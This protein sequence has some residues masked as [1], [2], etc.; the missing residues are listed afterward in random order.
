MCDLQLLLAAKDSIQEVY[1]QLILLILP[2]TLPAAT[3]AAAHA[4][5]SCKPWEAAAKEGLENVHGVCC[6][7]AAHAPHAAKGVALEACLAKFVVDGALVV[8]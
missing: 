1:L 7:E 6:L 4:I 3:H 5:H 8:V 2:S